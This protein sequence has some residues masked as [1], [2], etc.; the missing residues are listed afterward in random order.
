[1]QSSCISIIQISLSLLLSVYMEKLFILFHLQKTY[2][3]G[4]YSGHGYL[5][6]SVEEETETQRFKMTFTIDLYN[7][8]QHS[9]PNCVSDSAACIANIFFW[10]V[11]SLILIKLLQTFTRHS[12]FNFNEELFHFFIKC[13]RLSLLLWWQKKKKDIKFTLPTHSQAFLF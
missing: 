11:T 5:Y 13:F 4:N 8:L 3:L 2:F 1:M 6:S 9:V 12:Q 10:S 7:D